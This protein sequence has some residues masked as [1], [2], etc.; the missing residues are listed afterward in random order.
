MGQH[1]Q[2]LKEG[3]KAVIARQLGRQP[4]NLVGVAVRCPAGHPQV[5]VTHPV[6]Y[7]DGVYPEV[8]PTL[9]W[10]SC[11]RLVKEV[12]RLEGA[13]VIEDIQEAIF[14]N[15]ELQEELNEEHRQYAEERLAL[16]KNVT[17]NPLKE[18][19]PAQYDVLVHSGVGGIMDKGIKCLHTHFADYLVHGK[20]PVGRLVAEKLGDK[21]VEM[22]E[23]CKEEGQS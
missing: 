4:R 10:L 23:E 15:P 13:G 19:Y 17:L 11:P 20:N 6:M 12:S 3:D 21:I 7:H 14:H 2:P 9:Y 22:C 1:F 8:F 5:I 18:E 16:V